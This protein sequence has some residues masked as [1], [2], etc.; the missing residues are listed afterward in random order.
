M[1]ELRLLLKA[2]FNTFNAPMKI[3]QM[4]QYLRLIH[5]YERSLVFTVYL[6]ITWHLSCLFLYFKNKMVKFSKLSDKIEEMLL[7][8]KP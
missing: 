8:L 6:F 4:Y 5:I 1:K 3:S 2:L 7:T